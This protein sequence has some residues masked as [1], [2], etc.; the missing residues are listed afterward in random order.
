MLVEILVPTFMYAHGVPIKNSYIAI[1][2]YYTLGYTELAS[3]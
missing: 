3:Y 1:V 2:F